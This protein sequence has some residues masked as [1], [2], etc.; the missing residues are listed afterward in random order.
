MNA[1]VPAPAAL[2]HRGQP[3]HLCAS[4]GAAPAVP[5]SRARAARIS[6]HGPPAAAASASAERRPGSHKGFV[7]EMRFVAM[8][9]HTKDQAPSEGEQEQS[10]IPI[11]QWLPSHAEFMQFLVDS[12]E[13]YVYFEEVLCGGDSPVFSR[14]RETGLERVGPLKKDIAYLNGIG[15]ETP[16]PTE[17]AVK[18]VE[19]MKKLQAAGRDEAL[20]C[21]FY[22]YIFAHSAGGRMIGRMMVAKVLDGREMAFYQW[23]SDVKELLVPVRETI[24]QVAAEWPR[25]LK[26]DCLKETSL[27]RFPH[28]GLLLLFADTKSVP[29]LCLLLQW[30]DGADFS[31]FVLVKFLTLI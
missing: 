29:F 11:D 25:D 31:L 18:Y 28:P 22:N 10:A 7:E 24:D 13:V 4:R 5:P 26:D 15:V 1:F 23:E 2:V 6:M 3:G 27:V 30:K 9:L 14:F 16:Q 20:L 19:Y 21:H 17:A 12:L 8:R